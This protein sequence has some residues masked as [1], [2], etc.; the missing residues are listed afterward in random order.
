MFGFQ[1]H[2]GFW[3]DFGGIL[4]DDRPCALLIF[5]AVML[6]MLLG[7][8]GC[9]SRDGSALTGENSQLDSQSLV[10]A[11][12]PAVAEDALTAV[13]LTLGEG[14]V[15]VFSAGS[16]ATPVEVDFDLEGPWDFRRGPESLTLTIERVA[17]PEAPFEESFPD[18]EI[19]VHS[20]WKPSLMESRYSF[21]TVDADAWRAFGDAGAGGIVSYS[22]PSRALLFPARVGDQWTDAY[23]RIEGDIATA[24]VT[25]NRIIS[26]NSLE[27]PAGEYDAYLMQSRITATR[28]DQSVTTWDYVWLVPGVG[29]VAEIVSLPDEEEETFD[30][31]YSFYRLE[32]FEE[33]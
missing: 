6:L 17:K 24:I 23:E 4:Y 19:A 25:E 28:D 11:G 10:E 15:S 31:A 3:R 18:A 26:R 7:A 5:T 2:S 33:A 12:A 29:R 21:Q 30:R 27:V 14:A 1:R 16:T 20:S 22:G 9:G 8:S 13:D 32:S